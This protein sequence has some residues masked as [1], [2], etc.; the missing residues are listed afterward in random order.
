MIACGLQEDVQVIGLS[1]LSGAHMELFPRIMGACTSA[2]WMTFLVVA[3]GTIS[4]ADIPES[5]R[6]GGR[7]LRTRHP[8]GHDRGLHSRQRPGPSTVVV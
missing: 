5:R 1:I 2:T 4:K 3:G 8:T 7:G 6:W